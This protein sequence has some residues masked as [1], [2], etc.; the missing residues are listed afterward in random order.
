MPVNYNDWFPG[1]RT[2][3]FKTAIGRNSES[4]PYSRHPFV[5]LLSDCIPR[6][7]NKKI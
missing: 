7:L 5:C 1:R 4:V 3:E 6:D 2:R